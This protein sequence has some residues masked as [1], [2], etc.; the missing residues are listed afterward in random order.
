MTAMKTYKLAEVEALTRGELLADTLKHYINRGKVPGVKVPEG[1][2]MVWAITQATLDTLLS[3]TT[4]GS[5]LDL[6]SEW[7]AGLRSGIHSAKRKPLSENTIE[8][9]QMGMDRFWNTLGL[10]RNVRDINPMNFEH[11]LGKT[12]PL[13]Y[14]SR[15]KTYDAINSFLFF[16][17][18]RG[19][20]TRADKEA[21]MAMRPHRS[22]PPRRLVLTRD[23]LETFLAVADSSWGKKP[24]DVA[25]SKA[26]FRFYCFA[27]LRQSEAI[28]LTV[29]QVDLK[30]GEV[31]I[32]G[33]G[34]KFRW[35]GMPEDLREAMAN[36]MKYRPAS[37]KYSNVFLQA[38]GKPLTKSLVHSRIWRIRKR[39]GL[40]IDTHGLRRTFATL[41]VEQ[42][43]L[44]RVSKGL[45]HSSTDQTDEYTRVEEH[46]AAQDMKRLDLLGNKPKPAEPAKTKKRRSRFL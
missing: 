12:D 23:Q 32:L 4:E 31:Q 1:K 8:S 27:G 20:K 11:F 45:G 28:N 14:S 22:A 44:T 39:T 16:L 41:A 26:V 33:K 21:I 18:K 15:I 6:Q 17:I 3:D 9:H 2:R 35:I 24:F 38:N 10:S 13:M 5:Y 42:M 19:Y 46:A 34:N 36:W 37:E 29:D 30:S 7:L 25:L 43:S 40:T